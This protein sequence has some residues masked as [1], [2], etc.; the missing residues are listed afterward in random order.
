M[1]P[2]LDNGS[3][4]PTSPNKGPIRPSSVVLAPAFRHSKTFPD[5]YPTRVSH[6]FLLT[7]LFVFSLL[8]N[9]KPAK[10]QPV[11]AG[12]TTYTIHGFYVLVNDADNDSYS[13]SMQVAFQELESQ[14]SLIAALDIRAD[15]L[16]DMRT[17]KIFL[18]YNVRPD[19]A[20][21]YHPSRQWL[22]D[23]G[24]NPE[25]AES[26]EIANA[27]NFTNWSRQN[28]PWMVLH[29]LVHGYHH[30][31]MGFGHIPTV[32][33][34]INARDSGIY[35][36]VPYNPGG[37]QPPFQLEAYAMVNEI[38]YLAEISEAFF[39]END[40][41]PFN[42]SDLESHDPQGYALLMDLFI[43]PVGTFVEQPPGDV[44]PSLYPNPVRD[45]LRFDSVETGTVQIYD[46]T[47]RV[48]MTQDVGGGITNI[49]VSTLSS[50]L[51]L[52]RMIGGPDHSM[53]QSMQKI[54]VTR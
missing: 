10:A 39:G 43:N 16:E 42:R 44:L 9:R 41:Y 24:R 14:L 8:L 7:L 11:V 53:H 5:M 6:W 50:G 30:Q 38:E 36:S 48:V 12:F 21:W 31:M 32:E 34:F 17:V 13:S 33:A 29:E 23:N 3:D 15:V 51:Y 47:G 2:A 45:I 20:A 46:T 19:G 25:K 52:V 18:V 40:Y 49:D 27:V 37:G 22:I 35:Q 26:V 4:A 1:L 28:Q 54:V